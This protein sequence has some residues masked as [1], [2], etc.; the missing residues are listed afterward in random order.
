MTVVP[1]IKPYD[2]VPYDNVIEVE[3]QPVPN[4]VRMI[5]TFSAGHNAEFTQMQRMGFASQLT[6]LDKRYKN[7]S[8]S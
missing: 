1:G 5:V 2:N 3:F 6:K 7:T 4:G 8:P